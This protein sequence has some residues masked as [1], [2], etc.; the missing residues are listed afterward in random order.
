[1]ESL[2]LIEAATMR[3]DVLM[4]PLTYYKQTFYTETLQTELKRRFK[5]TIV[6]PISASEIEEAKKLNPLGIIVQQ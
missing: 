2:G 6:G 1:M 3:A 5:K 4:Y